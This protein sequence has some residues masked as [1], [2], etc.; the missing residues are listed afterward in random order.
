[1]VV[2]W[3]AIFFLAA[4]QL[5]VS[6]RLAN[7]GEEIEK[8]RR[9]TE[10]LI[11]QNRILEEELRQRESLVYLTQEAQKLGFVEAKSYYYLVPQI[12]V[13]MK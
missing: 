8:E 10:T 9:I 12:P 13:A 4:L 2:I 5:L 3:L 7:L 1:M 11:A 6:N